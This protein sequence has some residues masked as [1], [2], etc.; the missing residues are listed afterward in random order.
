MSFHVYLLLYRTVCP[1]MCMLLPY[2]RFSVFTSLAVYMLFCV[3][4][5]PCICSSVDMSFRLYIFSYICLSLRVYVPSCVSALSVYIFPCVY[6]F[7]YTF[8][9]VYVP[10]YICPFMYQCVC[11]LE[12]MSLYVYVFPCVNSFLCI[13]FCAYILTFISLRVYVSSWVLLCVSPFVYILHPPV[14]MSIHR[15][16]SLCKLLRIISL[17]VVHCS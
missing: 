17:Y 3:Y 13:S 12:Y 16:V 9:R 5:S 4:V 1:F 15:Y 14:S 11:P 2:I 10:L 8:L 6:S 7:M